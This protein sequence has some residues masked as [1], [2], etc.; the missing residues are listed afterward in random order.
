MLRGFSHYCRTAPP[1]PGQGGLVYSLTLTL[2][3]TFSPY[4][5]GANPISLCLSS[6]SVSLSPLFQYIY[7]DIFQCQGKQVETDH[8]SRN[9]NRGRAAAHGLCYQLPA[10]LLLLPAVSFL[11]LCLALSLYLYLTLSLSESLSLSFLCRS[12]RSLTLSFLHSFSQISP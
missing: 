2:T 3:L 10:G 6:L 8:D 12:K 1:A 9:R 4:F 7:K 5:S 11:C